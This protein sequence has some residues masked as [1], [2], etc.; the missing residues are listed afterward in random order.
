MR[1]I[2]SGLLIAI[3][4][5]AV[6]TKLSFSQDSK[7]HVYEMN[8][9][10]IPYEQLDEFIKFYEMYGKPLDAQ[11]EYIVSV[12][13][14]RH[15]FGPSWNI[16]FLTEYKDLEGF[17]AARKR[18]DELFEKMFTDKSKRDEIDKKFMGYLKGHTDALVNDYPNLE[19]MK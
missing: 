9:L 1:K 8:Y 11:N 2:K 6:F 12:K 19:K 4:V 3:I 5:F 16:C 14:F 15:N 10:T 13:L 18:G 7:S 17:V